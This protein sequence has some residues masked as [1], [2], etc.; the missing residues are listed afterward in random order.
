MAKRKEPKGTTII[1]FN[2]CG[3]PDDEL[4]PEEF[5]DYQL[6]VLKALSPERQ[7]PIR[8]GCPV[9]VIDLATGNQ[10]AAFNMHNV[11]PSELQKKQLGK[12]VY[13]A[14][15]RYFQD[16]ENVKKYEAWKKKKEAESDGG[17]KT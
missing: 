16:P 4:K 10:I 1:E 11:A 13:E 17:D 14:M 6:A 12:A 9:S 3:I 15:Q 5:N 8:R 2:H 7:A